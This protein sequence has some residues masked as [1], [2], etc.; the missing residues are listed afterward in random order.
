MNN[1]TC[2]E[3]GCSR[4]VRARGRCEPHY[5]KWIR[6][7]PKEDRPLPTVQERFLSKIRIEANGC[8]MWTAALD[9]RGYGRFAPTRTHIVFAHRF[10]LEQKLGRSLKAGMF[11]CH[12]C[13][14]PSCVNP[15]HLFEGNDQANV[16]DCVSKLRH[17]YG[18]RNGHAY[19]TNDDVKNIREMALHG[20]TRSKIASTFGTSQSHVGRIIRGERR[21]IA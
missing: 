4:T 7:V 6:T 16:D 8:W 21:R 19:L 14:M 3:D 13:D 20:E 9:P 10:S 17:A 12:T 15:D 5:D 1:R 18:E 11:A 2:I